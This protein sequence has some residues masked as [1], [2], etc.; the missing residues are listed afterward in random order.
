MKT[1]T[2]P[3]PRGPFLIPAE[4]EGVSAHS[5]ACCRPVLDGEYSYP[6]DSR[7]DVRTL[8]DIGT[9]CGAFMVWARGWWPSITT[10]IGYE[11]NPQARY[12]ATRNV[13][14]AYIWPD[15]VTT[16]TEVIL[17][18]EAAHPDNWGGMFIA[19]ANVT[20]HGHMIPTIHPAKLPAADAIKIDCEGCELEVVENYP[21]LAG[22]K[23]IM[24]EMHSADLIRGVTE[25]VESLGFRR[26][27][28]NP[29]ATQC[30]V[31]VWVRP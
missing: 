9:N 21:Y 10:M 22:C 27:R 31:R 25:R 2:I 15:A 23:V 30:D 4:P 5:E 11:P 29:D 24:C 26:V 3:G 1:R 16:R 14:D 20:P 18:A 19:Q 8:L 28:G 17:V 13:E 12:I 6:R 7:E